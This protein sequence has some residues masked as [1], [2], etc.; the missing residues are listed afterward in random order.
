[1][2]I[3][4]KIRNEGSRV[5]Y[6]MSGHRLKKPPSP[7]SYVQLR[8]KNEQRML[9]PQSRFKSTPVGYRNGVSDFRVIIRD[10]T[11]IGQPKD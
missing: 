6:V 5:D 11:P 9:M 4:E 7:A 8:L 2:I 3:G 10:H 1:M